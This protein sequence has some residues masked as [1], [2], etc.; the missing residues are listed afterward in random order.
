MAARLAPLL[1]LAAGSTLFATSC[2][3]GGR[4]EPTPLPPA[5]PRHPADEAVVALFNGQPVRWREVAEHLL[6]TNLKPSVDLYLKFRLLEDRKAALGIVHTPDELRRRAE[7]EV[8][9]T[10]Q[11]LGEAAFNAQLGREGTSEARY[12]DFLSASRRLQDMLTLDKIIRYDALLHDGVRIE[13]VVFTDESQARD[14][15][16][17]SLASGF[18]A[19]AAK[20]RVRLVE[21]FPRHVPPDRPP[22]DPWIVDAVFALKPGQA[23]DVETSRSNLFYVIRLVEFRKAAPVPY[24]EA[25]AKVLDSV[26]EDPPTVRDY[27]RWFERELSRA[28]V[29]Y[30]DRGFSRD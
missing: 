12:V 11:G 28:K 17:E 3:R 1:L 18:D 30:A 19:A 9:R 23:T 6:A 10:K 8:R 24:P 15:K 5:A 27:E 25:R 7:A 29:E 21:S 20:A 14:F 2:A 16:K 13:R 26:L 4:D 22:L